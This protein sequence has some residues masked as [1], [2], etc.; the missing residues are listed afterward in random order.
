MYIHTPLWS[1]IIQD[2][3]C[4]YVITHLLSLCQLKVVSFKEHGG[5]I[6]RQKD[7]PWEKRKQRYEE[8]SG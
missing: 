8:E 5:T 7:I 2:L 6:V 4:S 1:V 3:I